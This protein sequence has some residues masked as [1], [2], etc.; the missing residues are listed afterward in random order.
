M[1]FTTEQQKKHRTAF[2]EDCHQKAW[3]ASCNADFIAKHLDQLTADYT[4]LK[5]DDDK[6]AE[7]IKTLE[8]AVDEHTKDNRDKRKALQERRN[9]LSK[10]TQFVLMTHEQGQKTLAGLYQAI[11]TNLALAKHAEAWEW[12]EVQAQ[13]DEK[14]A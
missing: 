5:A 7:E 8:T 2:V 13:P 10:R 4:K 9:G 3:G 6:L 14:A 12:K 11:E 1:T